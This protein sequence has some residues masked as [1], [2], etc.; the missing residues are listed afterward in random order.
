MSAE[1]I[2]KGIRWISSL[3]RE[4]ETTDFGILCLTSENLSAPWLH[5][6]AGAL[7]KIAEARVVPI[8]Y[9]INPGDIQG[10]LG[11]FQAAVLTN[12]EEMRRVL[13]SMNETL[14][15]GAS[16]NWERT[17]DALWH[18][19]EDKIKEFIEQDII[20]IICPTEGA[21][22]E[23]PQRSGDRG[24]TYLVQGT[25][26]Y[27]PKDYVIWLLNASTKGEQWPQG[28]AIFDSKSGNWEGRIYLQTWLP[29]TIINA[30]V[31]PPTS[32]QFFEYYQQYG[33]AK[34]LSRLPDE[35]KNIATVSAHNPQYSP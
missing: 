19:V 9:E 4:L 27:L 12:K 35:C 20:K 28:S 3:A 24:F 29:E 17:F 2:G 6:E 8:L 16:R 25:L 33:N 18:Q 30:V 7:S 34:P 22:L 31:A 10:P 13:A 5:F 14:G 15:D 1:D 32:Q 21:M 26:K 11:D 23:N